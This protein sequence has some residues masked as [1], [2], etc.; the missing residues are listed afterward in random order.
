ME[1]TNRLQH[2][3]LALVTLGHFLNDS[4]GSFFAPIL[5]LLI[6]KLS[7]SLTAASGLASIPSIT[8]AL[9]QPL[10]GMA[11]DR[12]RGRKFII[13]GPLVSV[14][15]MGALGGVPH[16]FLVGLLLL[17]AG[18]GSAAF[19][20]QAVA[21]AG[22][23]SGAHRGFGIAVFTFG[24][25]FGFAVGPLAIIG[26]VQCF[27]L[28]R[29]YYIILPGLLGVLVL[30]VSLQ[31]PAGKTGHA[32]TASLVEAFRG[33][34][35]P[36]A[37]LFAIAVLREFTRLAVATF[38][39][40]MVAMQGHSLLAGGLTLSLFSLAGAVGGMV[41]GVLSDTWGRKSVIAVSG[42]LCVP[43]LHGVFHTDGLL[44]LVC[45]T[46][47]A[48]TLSGANSVI[49]AL[50]QELVP[51]RAGTASSVVMGLGWGVA[52][53]VLIGFGSVAEVIGVP[54]ALD[55]AM[56][57]PLLAFGLSLWLPHH[58]VLQRAHAPLVSEVAGREEEL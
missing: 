17:L 58:V 5:P 24:G 39:P 56:T 49:I 54:R 18:I 15:C 8:S 33:A 31:V 4:Y 53:V 50:A 28:D 41:G 16:P 29:S 10:Y 35:G 38:L 30:L 51:T 44:A 32:R 21:A 12:I 46:L 2:S 7:L 19:H 20:P 45:L 11:S 34:Q 6:E 57:L 27:G 23:V 9:F 14:V 55:I 26:A 37:L 42:L 36:M 52:G 25:S 43:L 40:I 47:A 22:T 3:R 1:A 48:G 13:L